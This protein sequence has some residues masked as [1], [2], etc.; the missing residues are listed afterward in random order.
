MSLLVLCA[1]LFRQSH[2]FPICVALPY[3]DSRIVLHK[4]CQILRNCQCKSILASSS[5]PGTSLGSSGS[6]GKIL[7]C[8]R[9][10][11][12]TVLPSLVPPRHT[13]DCS[14]IHFLHREL[15]DLCTTVPAR[16]LQETIVIIVLK[17]ISQFGSFEK[18]VYTLCLP[19]TGSTFACGSTGI[20]KM[21]W[22]R[23]DFLALGFPKALLKYFHQPSSPWIPVANQASHAIDLFLLPH[24][25]FCFRFLWIHAAGLSEALHFFLVLDFRCICWHQLRNPVMKMME[26]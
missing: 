2:L 19:E 25:Y 4:T 17:Q 24:L 15:C 13:D 14:S 6:P 5:A 16:L 9:M 12:S 20:H 26:K 23:L 8:I 22:K 18:C 10:I 21:T 1:L 3:N 7:I 11:V